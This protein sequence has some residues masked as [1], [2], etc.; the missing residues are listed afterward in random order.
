RELADEVLGRGEPGFE[1][2]PLPPQPKPHVMGV[3]ADVRG[4][5]RLVRDQRTSQARS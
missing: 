3:A 5:P 4:F 2:L 1:D